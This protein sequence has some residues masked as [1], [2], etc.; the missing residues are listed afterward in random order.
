M[1]GQTL[2]PHTSGRPSPGQL[3]LNLSRASTRHMN[4]ASLLPGPALKEEAGGGQQGKIITNLIQLIIIVILHI[5][6]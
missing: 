3:Q 1:S 6:P 2:S 5:H 4:P